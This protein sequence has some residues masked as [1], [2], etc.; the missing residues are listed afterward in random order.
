[1]SI[2]LPP[3][4]QVPSPNFSER[5]PPI[6]NL[7]VCHDCEGSYAGSVSWFAQRRSQVSAHIV[8]KEDGSEATQMVPFAKKAWH[9]CNYNSRSIGVEIAG[10]AKPGFSADELNAD[11][12]IVAWLLRKFGIPCQWAGKGAPKPG[13]CSHFDLGAAGGGHTDLTTDPVVWAAFQARV[14]AAYAASAGAPLAQWGYVT[15]VP[16]AIASKPPVA[17]VGYVPTTDI[18]SDEPPSTPKETELA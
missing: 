5:S 12:N 6:I 17:P 3:L 10:Y 9:A 11:A 16:I 4:K 7:V 1:M 15:V 2:T 18:R 14:E 13:F 8:L